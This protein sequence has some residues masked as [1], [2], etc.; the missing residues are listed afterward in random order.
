MANAGVKKHTVLMCVCVTEMLVSR[1]LVHQ[2]LRGVQQAA[3]E[4]ECKTAAR[5][6]LD[7]YNQA[8]VRLHTCANAQMDTQTLTHLLM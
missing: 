5:I 3:L 6:A 1:E 8:L 7:N 2:D 4:E